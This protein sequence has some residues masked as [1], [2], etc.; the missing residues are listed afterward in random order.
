M[1]AALSLEYIGASTWDS[2]KDFERFSRVSGFTVGRPHDWDTADEYMDLPGPRV[3]A[4]RI[5]GP[6][7]GSI[8]PLRGHRDYRRANSKGTRGVMVVYTLE[9]G[10]IYRIKAPTSWRSSV[11]YF[12][13]VDATGE[14]RR[15]RKEESL[16]WASTH[17]V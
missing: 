5:T 12:A 2:L 14:I 4:Y 15:M 17:W 3:M 8:G 13:V 7:A 6:D 1:K 9:E 10:T 16:A 11:Q